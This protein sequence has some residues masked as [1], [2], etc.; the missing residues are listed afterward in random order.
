[1][2]G[3]FGAIR[4]CVHRALMFCHQALDHLNKWFCPIMTMH[5]AMSLFSLIKFALENFSEIHGNSEG[6]FTKIR[7]YLLCEKRAVKDTKLWGHWL[8]R[9]QARP[10]ACIKHVYVSVVWTFRQLPR[11][12]HTGQRW[13]IPQE[14]GG[15]QGHGWPEE[16]SA[17]CK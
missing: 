13:P 4:L 7:P 2:K 6:H 16:G 8:L 12:H 9:L 1:M 3:L 11:C 14:E 17:H 15:D 10:K 5:L